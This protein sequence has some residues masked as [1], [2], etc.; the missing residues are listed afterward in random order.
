MYT[1]NT[2]KNHSDKI[3]GLAAVVA[4]VVG[5]FA[6]SGGDK[7]NYKPCVEGKRAA[8]EFVNE[9]TGKPVPST[10]TLLAECKAEAEVR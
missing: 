8:A 10:A 1:T 7:P 2:R 4:I 3:I 6:L 9:Q 5:L